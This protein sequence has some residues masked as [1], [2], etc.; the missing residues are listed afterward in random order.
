[1]ETLSLV[2]EQGENVSGCD[3][4]T[5]ED[6]GDDDSRCP[7]SSLAGLD[8]ASECG[9]SCRCGLE[10]GNRLS[11]KG[12]TVRLKI[13]RDRRKGWGLYA[14]QLIQKGQFICEYA[15]NAFIT[16]YTKA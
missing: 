9:R 2:D 15:G 6:V 3:C 7:C 1:M 13:V 10:C 4:D 5:C 14:D 16:T 12:I 11:Q 8:V